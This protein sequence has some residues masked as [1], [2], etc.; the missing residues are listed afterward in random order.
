MKAL[1]PLTLY[2]VGAVDFTFAPRP[3]KLNDVETLSGL[4]AS[5]V[6]PLFCIFKE[7]PAQLSRQKQQ[8]R[9]GEQQSELGP[10]HCATV[11]VNDY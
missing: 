4:F 2:V 10:K 9:L 3:V 5:R 8:P 11:C 6:N 7:G 1:N